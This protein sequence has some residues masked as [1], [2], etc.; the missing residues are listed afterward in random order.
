MVMVA[1]EVSLSYTTI[2]GTD[3]VISVN[4]DEEELNLAS[5]GIESIDLTQL[6]RCKDLHSLDLSKNEISQIDTTPLIVHKNLFS[7]DLS[8]NQLPSLNITPLLFCNNI[9]HLG[10]SDTIPLGIDPVAQFA[11]G[12]YALFNTISRVHLTTR[13][14]DLV[15]QVGW[16]S[17][18]VNTKRIFELLPERQWFVAQRG[19]LAGLGYPEIAAFDGNPSCILSSIPDDS[20]FEESRRD[21]QD[22]VIALLKAQVEDGGSTHFLDINRLSITAGMSLVPC[23]IENRKREMEDLEIISCNGEVDARIFYFTHYGRLILSRL[24]YRP[25]HPQS[26]TL[27]QILDAI[28][29]SGFEPKIRNSQGAPSRDIGSNLSTGLRYFLEMDARGIALVNGII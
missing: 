27:Q 6:E 19:F 23:I 20:T 1:D 8:D 16:K 5:R 14:E 15:E 29:G 22:R 28:K 10:V 17:I 25:Y 9:T 7:I 12:N 2:S 11:Y 3:E 13:Y 26:V 21:I 24:G 4:V 18:L